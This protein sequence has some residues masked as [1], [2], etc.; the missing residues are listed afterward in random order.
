MGWSLTVGDEGLVLGMQMGMG[1]GEERER[2]EGGRGGEGEERIEV[3]EEIYFD[4]RS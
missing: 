3:R 2:G 1:R 4:S